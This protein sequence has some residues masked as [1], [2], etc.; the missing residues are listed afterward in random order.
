MLLLWEL[1]LQNWDLQSQRA[2]RF[3]QM[4]SFIWHHNQPLLPVPITQLLH[5]HVFSKTLAPHFHEFSWTP[6]L[7][8]HVLTQTSTPTL[9]RIQLDPT[10]TLSSI[11]LNPSHKLSISKCILDQI[12]SA[13]FFN[14][15]FGYKV[16][17]TLPDICPCIMTILEIVYLNARFSV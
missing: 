13:F 5:F 7:Y 14:E 15:I 16:K 12:Q 8:F 9:P 6:A 2:G 1:M 11:Q 17:E 10:P 3:Y 4:V